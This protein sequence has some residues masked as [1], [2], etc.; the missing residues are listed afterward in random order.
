MATLLD[1]THLSPSWG[2][3][4]IPAGW[5]R[6]GGGDSA[7]S[8]S[9]G[10]ETWG[11]SLA[12]RVSI[13]GVRVCSPVFGA[14][15][16]PTLWACRRWWLATRVPGVRAPYLSI[17]LQEAADLSSLKPRLDELGVPLYAVVKGTSRMRLRTSS[18]ISKEK[19]SW[20]SMCGVSQSDTDCWGWCSCMK[21]LVAPSLSGQELKLASVSAAPPSGQSM[22]GEKK[23]FKTVFQILLEPF[24]TYD[25][26]MGA[27][28]IAK[29]STGSPT[30]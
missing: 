28:K 3:A 4:G 14:F 2:A 9:L 13:V 5:P 10:S 11:F 29:S 25:L 15:V 27:L 1:Q 24:L 18:L 23:N 6:T 26:G 19:S 20:M 16:F 7:A 12:D 8:L 22:S 30:L 21:S 17:F